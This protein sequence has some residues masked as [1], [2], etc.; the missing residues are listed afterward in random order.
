M[1]TVFFLATCRCR[2]CQSS[3][4]VAKSSPTNGSSSSSSCGSCRR[5]SNTF[6]RTR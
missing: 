5:D 1:S 2:N 4:R 3:R 6:R